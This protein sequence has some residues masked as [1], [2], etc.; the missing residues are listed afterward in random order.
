MSGCYR[1]VIVIA[2]ELE[3]HD[4]GEVGVARGRAD[5]IHYPWAGE[6]GISEPPRQIC[7]PIVLLSLD[8]KLA[9]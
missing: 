8:P 6:A 1:D 7:E 4:R 5:F 9:D 3:G 2:R